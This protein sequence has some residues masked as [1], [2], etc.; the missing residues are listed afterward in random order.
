MAKNTAPKPALKTKAAT[1]ISI[2]TK[3]TTISHL[4]KIL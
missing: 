4:A 3:E 1:I 2:M